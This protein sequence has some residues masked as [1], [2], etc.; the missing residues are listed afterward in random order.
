[1]EMS[2]SLVKKITKPRLVDN[3]NSK[4]DD[5]DNYYKTIK[6]STSFNRNK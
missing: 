5:N 4:D 2:N 6:S 3:D 1:M